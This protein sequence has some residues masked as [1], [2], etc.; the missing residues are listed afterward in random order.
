MKPF[1]RQQSVTQYLSQ[2]SLSEHR[3][4][5]N[6][7]QNSL[8][9]Y[10]S[11]FF[12]LSLSLCL[13]AEAATRIARLLPT[14]DNTGAQA[15]APTCLAIMSGTPFDELGTPFD[16]TPF[17]KLGT[18]FEGAFFKGPTRLCKLSRH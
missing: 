8:S 13:I 17:E 16:G 15:K 6:L 4:L 9:E 2:K 10:L 5:Q 11:Q 3:V 14:A 12:C 18:P 7:S 1:S